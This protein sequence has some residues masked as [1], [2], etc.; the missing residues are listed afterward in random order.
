MRFI[1][2]KEALRVYAETERCIHS[3]QEDM[4]TALLRF[5]GGVVG[6]LTVNWLTPTKVRELQV[7]GER[8]MFKVDYLTQDLYFYGKRRDT[9]AKTGNLSSVMR[10]VSE[11]RMIRHAVAKAE[12]LRTELSQFLTAV[13][14][15][16]AL[17]VSG[18]DGIQALRM[19][20]ALVQSGM[21][22]RLVHLS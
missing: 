8:G 20:H 21:E 14:G 2:G 4:L 6:T 19:A 9:R 18:E 17:I 3:S 16:P 12:P 15:K 7:M 11:G 10:G 5:D 13:M 22:Q 1:T